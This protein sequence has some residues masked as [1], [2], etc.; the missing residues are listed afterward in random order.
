MAAGENSNNQDFSLYQKFIVEHENFKTLPSKTN[1]QGEIT[2]V[3][4]K[5][6][7]R[8]KWWDDLKEKLNLKDRASVARTIHPPELGG[9]KPCQ[10]CGRTMNIHAVYPD[11]R[12]VKNLQHAFPDV[13]IK[14][15]GEEI[16]QICSEIEIAH[17]AKGLAL[18]GTI[19]KYSEKI[20]N[21]AQLATQLIK[22]GKYLSPGV[23]SNAPDRLD[24]FHTYNACCRSEK[25][26][27]R[28]ASNLSRYSTD[29]RAYE[30]WADGNWRGADRLMGKYHSSLEMV[31]CPSCG[32]VE[33]MSA[34]HI[35]PISLGFMH[36][37][38]F[39]SLCIKCNGKK[40]NRMSFA[41]V[42]ALKA[43]ELAGET[44]ISW[45]S[46][47]IWDR[48]KND[49]SDDDSA[50]A[51]SKILRKN[52]HYVMCVLSD[53]QKAGHEDFLKA[54]LHPELAAFDY[55]FNAFDVATGDFDATR[56]PIDSLNTQRQAERYVRI[57]FEALSDYREKENRKSARWSNKKADE[58]LAKILNDLPVKS[59]IIVRVDIDRLFAHLSTTLGSVS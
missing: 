42:T 58:M 24:G 14:H 13:Q 34:D 20:T 22:K 8:A 11:A 38:A 29:R 41:D 15:F 59:A 18:V 50:L 3:K 1:S 45:H 40:N 27:G 28:H 10:I 43:A 35:G 48:I 31:P 57:S 26:T 47:A 12:T 7:K 37:M 36:R 9:F 17:G 4:V 46:R 55:V 56:V 51:A 53:I 44:V 25:D 39:H 23:M 2:W 49:I 5:D 30:N 21:A 32:K 33:K 16:S 19:F 54:Y 52:M 6:Q